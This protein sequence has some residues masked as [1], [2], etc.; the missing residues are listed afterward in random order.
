MDYTGEFLLR[1]NSVVQQDFDESGWAR[2][3]LIANITI[4]TLI[5]KEPGKWPLLRMHI[6]DKA[7]PVWTWRTF[8]KGNVPDA[9]ERQMRIYGIGY[10][11]RGQKPH[12]MWVMP[13]GHIEAG[14]DNPLFADV[15]WHKK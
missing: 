6:P 15:M 14:T 10:K 11:K 7:K 8:R 4:F 2:K 5:P 3:D 1:D 13:G 9:V 12:L